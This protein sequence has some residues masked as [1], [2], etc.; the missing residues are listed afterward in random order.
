VI[1]RLV[2]ITRTPSSISWKLSRSPVTTI[3]SMPSSRARR[4]SVAITSSAS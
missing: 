4:A 2:A 3:T 1:P